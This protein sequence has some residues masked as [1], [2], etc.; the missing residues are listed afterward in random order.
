LTVNLAEANTAIYLVGIFPVHR[1]AIWR[2]G[3]SYSFAFSGKTVTGVSSL[4][5]PAIRNR[6]TMSPFLNSPIYFLTP[7]APLP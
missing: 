5:F 4:S 6:L 3:K 1:Y 2:I 7:L